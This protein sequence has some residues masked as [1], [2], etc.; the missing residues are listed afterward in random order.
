MCTTAISLFKVIVHTTIGGELRSFKD[1]HTQSGDEKGGSGKK[2]T[3]KEMWTVFGIVLCVVLFVYLSIVARRAVDQVEAHH[4]LPSHSSN[5]IM[6]GNVGAG[7]GSAMMRSISPSV[8]M[9]SWGVP[10]RQHHRG[11]ERVSTTETPY[12]E[13][14]SPPSPPPGNLNVLGISVNEAS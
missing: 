2:W 6:G 7:G 12:D 3:W 11:Y 10:L 13:C 8:V 1:Y 5:G 4:G 14:V 9:S